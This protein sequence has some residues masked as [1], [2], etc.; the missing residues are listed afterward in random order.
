MNLGGI[1]VVI[2]VLVVAIAAGPAGIAA[3]LAGAVWLWRC[4]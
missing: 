3:A 1:S 2:A 4:S